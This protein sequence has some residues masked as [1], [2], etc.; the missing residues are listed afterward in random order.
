MSLRPYLVAAALAIVIAINGFLLVKERILDPEI[1]ERH[2]V[3]RADPLQGLT[4][5]KASRNKNMASFGLPK[6]MAKAAVER[7][8]DLSDR[9]GKKLD[10]MVDQIG[11]PNALADAVC[12]NTNQLR[13]RYGALRFLVEASGDQRDPIRLARVSGFE[14]QDWAL[15]SPISEVY[16]HVELIGEPKPDATLMAIA[17][18]L[19]A[20]EREVLEDHQPW[21]RGLLPS[22]WSWARVRK[23]NKG[24]SDRLIEYFSLMHLTLERVNGPDGICR[25]GEGEDKKPG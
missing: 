24:I 25:E 3:Q 15:T 12:G 19:Q 6:P 13:P 21:G 5:R 16:A 4:Y 20:K 2:M 22:S 18:I 10:A 8:R 11:D 1:T 23:E 14:V 17:A 7:M 9:W